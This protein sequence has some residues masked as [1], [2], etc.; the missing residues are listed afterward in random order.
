MKITAIGSISEE[1]SGVFIALS[2]FSQLGWFTEELG[3]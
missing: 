2:M 1:Q 3:S